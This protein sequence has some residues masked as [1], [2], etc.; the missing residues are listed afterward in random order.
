MEA[1]GEVEIKV[2]KD[3]EEVSVMDHV[4]CVIMEYGVLQ[5]VCWD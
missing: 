2:S 3:K 5:D 1:E 4:T